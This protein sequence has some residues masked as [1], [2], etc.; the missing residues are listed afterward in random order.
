MPRQ[1]LVDKTGHRDEI[2]HL[3]IDQK[4]SSR[5]VQQY[6]SLRWGVEIPDSS[7]RTWRQRRVEQRRR[8]NT[9]PESW[10]GLPDASDTSPK[11]IIAR[12]LA[13]GDELP[14]IMQKRL[15]LIRLQEARIRLDTEHE[16]AMGKQFTTNGKEI[17]LLNRM[18]NDLRSDMQDLGLWPKT[19]A[20]PQV[21]A[22][23]YAAGGNAQAVAAS[24][25]ALTA[26][27]TRP[28][29]EMFPDVDPAVIREAGRTLVLLRREQTEERTDSDDGD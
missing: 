27:D 20:A 12:L 3:L 11:A 18:Y 7:L 15:A 2:E 21:Q 25:G 17:D 10:S 23:I 8:L 14:D 16:L 26:S 24:A 22:N 29:G 4:W 6:A 1:S 28:L 9:L 13:T 19:E 5:A